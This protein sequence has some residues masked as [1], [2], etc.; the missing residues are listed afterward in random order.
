[1][2][3][4]HEDVM[5][6]LKQLMF[7]ETNTDA[8]TYEQ[9]REICSATEKYIQEYP[10]KKYPFPGYEAAEFLTRNYSFNTILDVGFGEGTQSDYFISKGK[11]VT[12]IDYGLSGRTQFFKNSN[13]ANVIIDDFLKHDFVCEFDCVW[14]SHVL[15]HQLD[16]QTFLEKIVKLCREGGIIAI[17]VPPYKSEITSGHV[18]MW[19]LGLL[20]WRMVIAGCN[21]KDAHLKKYGYNISIIV[22]KESVNAISD[23]TYDIGCMKS[24]KKYMPD[25]IDFYMEGKGRDIVFDGNIISINW[26]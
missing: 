24:L 12:A 13:S 3:F 26:D 16:P 9:I 14:C 18:S 22:E 6:Y 10:F 4:S 20:L 11:N 15:E 21:C 5:F 25:C 19:N 23:F 7:G 1:M 8:N 2:G 17:T